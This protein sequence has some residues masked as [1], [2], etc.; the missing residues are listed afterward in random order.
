MREENV[1]AAERGRRNAV[2]VQ[3]RGLRRWARDSRAGDGWADETQH[4]ASHA[5][6]T[7]FA[8]GSNVTQDNRLLSQGT[9][10]KEE[11]GV[12]LSE[13]LRPLE[14]MERGLWGPPKCLTLHPSNSIVALHLQR[15]VQIF[16]PKRKRWFGMVPRR[17]S[18]MIFLKSAISP[19]LP[20]TQRPGPVLLFSH[21]T[22]HGPSPCVT[23]ACAWCYGLSPS[24]ECKLR[25]GGNFWLGVI[26]LHPGA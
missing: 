8:L 7:I 10:Q 23:H 9:G 17:P 12:R 18:R 16:L 13:A 26:T 4:P 19:S 1:G 2:P 14:R 3:G 22:C 24:L 21:S 11:N 6:Q 25:E 5:R 15:E 20:P